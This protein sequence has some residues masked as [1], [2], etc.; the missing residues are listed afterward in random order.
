MHEKENPH[1]VDACRVSRLVSRGEGSYSIVYNDRHIGTSNRRHLPLRGDSDFKFASRWD[2]VSLPRTDKSNPDKDRTCGISQYR[3][4]ES[5]S[6][7]G[8]EHV[9]QNTPELLSLHQHFFR[10]T[11][12]NTEEI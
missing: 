2:Q 10:S 7:S 8:V 1:G 6:K 5:S 11:E 12:K 3:I 4:Q 9:T